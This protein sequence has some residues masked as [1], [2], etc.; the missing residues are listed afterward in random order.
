MNIYLHVEMTLRELDSKLLLATLAASRG[1][2][3]IISDIESIEKGLK[4][5]V[6]TP[7]IF[8]TKSLTPSKLKIARHQAMIKNGTLITSIDEENDLMLHGYNEFAKIRYS[9]QTVKDSAAIFG[10]GPEDVDTLKQVYPKHSL[11]IHKTGSPRVDLWKS[12]LSKYW[13][14]PQGV[15]KRPFLLVNSNMSYANFEEPFRDLISRDRMGGYFQRDPDKFMRNFGFIA[16]NYQTIAAFI[17]AIKYL[18]EFNNGYDI[19]LRPHPTESIENWKVYLEGIPNVHVI[20]EGSVTPWIKNAFAVM[21]NGCTTALETTVSGTPLLSYVPFKQEYNF[22]LANELGFRIENKEE[23][24]R[25]VNTL[26]D[27]QQ[28]NNKNDLSKVLPEQVSKK[29][30]IDNSELAA[31]KMIKIWES[32]A[33]TNNISSKSSNWTMFKWLLK[34]MKING[35]IGKIFKIILKGNF[36]QKLNYKFP[37]L[38][39]QDI[40]ERFDRMQSVLGVANELE[41]KLLSDRT[42]LIKQ[43]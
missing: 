18:S 17:E 39:S 12:N 23:L 31:D 42:I 11:K 10:W 30:Y 38:D 15:P 27:V 34:I 24:L 43:R 22:D 8:H 7:G 36:K 25:K 32:L 26:F 13:G 35:K 14:V 33:N 20:R 4:R 16:E 2:Q 41:C 40:R 5:G 28:S 3:V 19:V 37:P 21:H 9:E 6:L 1:H 29:I